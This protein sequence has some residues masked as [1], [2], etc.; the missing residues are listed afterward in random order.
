MLNFSSFI[1]GWSGRLTL[2][3]A[4]LIISCTSHAL[5]P[6][7]IGILAYRPI[8]ETLKE[9]QPLTLALKLAIPDRDFAIEI[10]NYDELDQA[11][12]EH[13]LNFVLTNPAH[14]IFLK[15]RIGLSAPLATRASNTQNQTS[16][17]D[18]GVIFKRTNRIDI[19]S[20]SD[21]KGR[22]IA[23]VNS[24]SLMG[25]LAQALELKRAGIT[26]PKDATLIMTGTPHDKI[27]DKVLSGAADVGF[28]RSGVLEALIRE[29]KIDAKKITVLNLQAQTDSPYATS[30]A[31]Y[32]EWPFSSTLDTDNILRRRVAA[33]LL[34]L[35]IKTNT[36]NTR[37]VPGFSIPADYSAIVD[38]LKELRLPPFESIPQFTSQDIFKRYIWQITAGLISTA[39]MLFLLL[40]LISIRRK[41]AMQNKEVRENNQKMFSLMNAMSEG[42]YGFDL[43]GNCTFIN[44]AALRLLGY[45]DANELMGKHLHTVVHHTHLNES[46]YPA[47]QCNIYKAMYEG[48]SINCKDEVFWQKNGTPIPVEYWSNPIQIDGKI[49]G[50]VATFTD[51][52]ARIAA[53]EALRI[54]TTRLDLVEE[55]SKIGGWDYNYQT[56]ITA[57]T[58]GLAR[59][60]GY[61]NLREEWNSNTFIN[62]VLEEDR[63]TVMQTIQDAENTQTNWDL[64]CRIQRLDGE[65]RWIRAFSDHQYNDA[66]GIRHIFGCIR[67]VTD[68]HAQLQE[69]QDS[70]SQLTQARVAAEAAN[71]SKSAFL[72]NMSH[73][74]RTPMNAIIGMSEMALTHATQ[75]E[76]IDQL[77]KVKQSSQHLLDLINDILD[78]S[79]IEADQLKLEQLGFSLD[80]VLTNLS[81]LTEHK[82]T[83]KGLA[84][85]VTLPRLLSHQPLSGDALRLGQILINLVSNAI[86]FTRQ[87]SVSLSITQIASP[88][89]KVA[90]IFKVQDTGIG[91]PAQAQTR[92]FNAFEQ[93][94]SS[95][96]RQYGGTG[97]GLAISKR[98]VELMGGRIGVESNPD[99]GSTFWFTVQFNRLEKL[100]EIEL[101]ESAETAEI[102]LQQKR[103]QVKV[104][105]V[106]DDLFNQE[107]SIWLLKQVG[108][109]VD[110]AQNGIEAVEKA[111]NNHYD[112]VLMD[113]QMPLMNGLDASK[114][115]RKLAGWDNT[116][117][118]AMSANAFDEDR[119][120]SMEA[121]MNDHI[122][123]PVSSSALYTT[124]LK[125]LKT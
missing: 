75:H 71:K 117:I 61:P 110:L 17:L 113:I 38:L 93:A 56:K 42:T 98:L 25:Y 43:K 39:A 95:T 102:Q 86:K 122:S 125:H 14:Y 105:L 118:L 41:L 121:G 96:T 90:L 66:Q 115:I 6:V 101:L 82:A 8:P 120:H 63:V 68:R 84:F 114:A 97:L 24:Q 9:Y 79:K 3:G 22:T 124:L 10:M 119:R 33:A 109:F 116:P 35:N 21:L 73:E 34:T 80:H 51:I 32:P 58:L 74:L 92:L 55:I 60:F 78:L 57:R 100:D 45:D 111:K 59:I 107:V 108:F 88:P 4:M 81:N 5:E 65:I 11:V 94:D 89:E 87:G 36:L 104:L 46:N 106:E 53:E 7:K 1:Y 50:G 72:A 70:N 103:P 62:H 69:L 85:T 40:H 49:I 64:E 83:E 29:G 54:K 26:L 37:E 18:G 99:E 30:T 44:Q 15:H 23:T 12:S 123:K 52:S 48:C 112:L 76:Q 20:L 67:D 16:S 47:A 31:L 2:L 19:Q 28:L 27:V 91:I 77:S 13:K